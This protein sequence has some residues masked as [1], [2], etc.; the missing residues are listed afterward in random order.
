MTE[1]ASST[2]TSQKLTRASLCQLIVV[3]YSGSLISEISVASLFILQ[4]FSIETDP[5]L[6]ELCQILI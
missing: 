3:P 1:I 5:L 2:L 6:V 4:S